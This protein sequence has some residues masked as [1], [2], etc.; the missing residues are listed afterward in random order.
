MSRP[1]PGRPPQ[2]RWFIWLL[3]VLALV[4][5][6]DELE[7]FG[8]SDGPPASETRVLSETIVSPTAPS[9]PVNTT[10]ATTVPVLLQPTT[11]STEPATTTTEPVTT[12]TTR[13]RRTT[14][15]TE[16]EPTSTIPEE[17]TTTVVTE[18]PTFPTLP[19][20]TPG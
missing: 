3:F 8:S 19:T 12:T 14:T 11:T 16:P 5:I 13:P 2:S 1:A 4:L 10:A 18:P 20:F 15:T 17:T 6:V 7:P 9:T